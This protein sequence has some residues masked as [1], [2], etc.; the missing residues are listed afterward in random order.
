VKL[1]NDKG[2]DTVV[3]IGGGSTIEKS[4]SS[5]KQSGLIS[6]VGILTESKPADLIRPLLFGGKICKPPICLHLLS[7]EHR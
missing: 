3:E 6:S 4:I 7:L 5:T 1:T 2:F